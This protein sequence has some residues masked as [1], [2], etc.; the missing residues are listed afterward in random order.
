MPA[1]PH[2]RLESARDGIL[3]ETPDA[4]IRILALD[5]S[6]LQQV[7]SAAEAVLAYPEPTVDIL[8]NN[9]GIMMCPYS[10]TVDGYELQFATCHLGHFLFTNLIL[11]KLVASAAPRVINVSSLGH[12]YSGIRWDDVGFN[13]GATYDKEEA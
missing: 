12:Q 8:V 4:N 3:G 11:P 10:T 7:R 13:G 5:L 1:H 2:F 9:A 6:S